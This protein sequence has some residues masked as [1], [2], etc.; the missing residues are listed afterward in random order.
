M[1]AV[2]CITTFLIFWRQD[3]REENKRDCKPC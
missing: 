2:I 3:K 1:V